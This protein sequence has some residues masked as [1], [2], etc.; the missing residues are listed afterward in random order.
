VLLNHDGRR[1]VDEG[2][3]SRA[4][5]YAKFGQR[6]FEQPYHEAFIVVDSKTVEHVAHMGPGRPITGDSIESLVRRLDIE[7]VERAV[8]TIRKFNSACGPNEF[9]PDALDGNATEGV[10][11]SKSNWAVPFDEPPFTGY[12]V[13]G[14]MTFAF[15]VSL[16]LRTPRSSIPATNPSRGRSLPGTLPGDSFT[17]TIREVLGS[18]TPPCSGK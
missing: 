9:D 10:A 2:E 6:I 5:T 17:I 4:H 3:D 11:P 18:P 14:G 15:G 13:I 7:N 1:F 16:S 12:P 8:E